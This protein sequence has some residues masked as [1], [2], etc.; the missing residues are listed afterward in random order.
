MKFR[1]AEKE[2]DIFGTKYIIRLRVT[3]LNMSALNTIIIRLEAG[4]AKL[5]LRDTFALMPEA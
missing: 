4:I 5:R 3:G 2:V 1:V